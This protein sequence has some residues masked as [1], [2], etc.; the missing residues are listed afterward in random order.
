MMTG[1]GGSSWTSVRI[2]SSWEGFG[3]CIAV[4][5]SSPNTL[6]VGAQS[7]IPSQP[8]LFRSTNGGGTWSEITNSGWSGDGNM[9]SVAI[10][11]TTPTTVLAATSSAI[12]RTTNGGT[13]WTQTSSGTMY[14]WAMQY[15]RDDPSVV[16]AGGK[17]YFLRSLN[18]GVTWTTHTSGLPGDAVISIAADWG[19]SSRV[20][21]VSYAGIYR[22]LNTGTSWSAI[23]TG[24]YLGNVLCLHQPNTTPYTLYASTESLGLFRTVDNGNSWVSLGTPLDCGN[25]CAVQTQFDNPNRVLVLEG[26]G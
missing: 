1:N 16:V 7:R 3:R 24:L 13:S 5:E 26:V 4:S 15:S 17:T 19:N 18:G 23:N 25:L 22:S 9:P 8:K 10:H 20:Y 2:T 6:Y 11:P 21:T 14:H 12:Y